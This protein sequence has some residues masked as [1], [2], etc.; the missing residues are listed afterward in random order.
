MKGSGE[1][2]AS[3]LP[4]K[5]AARQLNR[6]TDQCIYIGDN[7]QVDFQ[8]AKD[9]EMAT[10]RLRYGEFQE[11]STDCKVDATVS[12]VADLYETVVDLSAD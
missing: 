6:A 8:G 7:P 1:G 12:D 3:P 9:V 11:M 2:F 10:I 4:F 5:Q